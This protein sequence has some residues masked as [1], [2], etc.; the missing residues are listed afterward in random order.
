M[1]AVFAD[2]MRSGRVGE[3]GAGSS[4][5]GRWR[6]P[7][8]ALAVTAVV[9]LAGSLALHH[10]LL[11]RL[12][13][14]T[15]GSTSSDSYV[16]VWWMR[17]LPWSF[18]HGAN[19]LVTTYYH[20]PF[21]VN[22]MWNSTV[23]VLAALF[24]PITICAGPVVAYNV[25]MLLGPVAS[26]LALALALGVWIER[27]WPRAVAG[28]LYGF[29]PFMIAHSAVGH[30]NLVWAVLPPVLLWAL[31]TVLVAPDPL[32]WRTGAVAGLAFAVQTVL[33]TQTVALCAVVVVVVA[34]VLAARFPRAALRRVPVVARG[35]AACVATYVVLAGY[36]LYL[37]LAGPAR[38]RAQIRTPEVTNADAVNL[39]VPT[40]L[41]KL[42]MGM[43]PLAQ[44][45]HTHLGE[46]G[47]YVGGALLLVIA[48]A[49]LT[50]RRQVVRVVAAVGV[51]AW[52]LSLGVDLVVLGRD[53]GVALPWRPIATVPLI[54][55]IETM[56]FQLVVA[57]CVA[58]IIALWCDRLASA[59]RGLRRT[60]ALAA[61]GA[62]L[63][64]WLPANAQVATPVIV[65]AYFAAGAPGLTGDDV[66]ETYPRTTAVWE[67]GARPM[68]WQAASGFAYRTTG[69]YSIT[70]DPT[71]DVL[72]EAPATAYLQ[73]AVAVADGAVP[74]DP[75]ASAAALRELRSLGVTAVVVVP[76]GRDV[77]A[78]LD[79]TRRVTGVPANLV[80]D[81]WLFRLPPAA[82]LS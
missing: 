25:A 9:Y 29:S 49:V 81:V 30:V 3:V 80:D 76:E 5:P 34:L 59:P 31:H 1:V 14:A 7:G 39:L 55:E 61:T 18:P 79:W 64:T 62:A 72:V 66:V 23:P 45:L 77:T 12:A 50:A 70:S 71:H 69:G 33:F 28:F 32:P 63:L 47:G 41:T 13:A 21:G 15:A 36:P 78:V 17:W 8:V 52:V 82:G 27:W 19:P 58:A 67:G 35:A 42:Q 60:A 11:R 38:P 22:G 75:A 6:V 51:V 16:F 74:P 10:R 46:Q 44:K 4:A 73:Q 26:G 40:R 48:V 68:L 54:G 37:V 56:R 53:T 20:A 24:S 43:D 57:L 2:P 65:P